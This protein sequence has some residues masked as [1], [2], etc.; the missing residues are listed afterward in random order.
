MYWELSGD[1]QFYLD[2]KSCPLVSFF[3]MCLFS[4]GDKDLGPR[5]GMEGGHG[6]EEVPG[7]SLVRLLSDTFSRL[8]PGLDMSQNRLDYPTSQFEN[9]RNGL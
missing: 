6:K 8:G 3:L 5:D 2:Y 1:S 4:T 9:L 7:E